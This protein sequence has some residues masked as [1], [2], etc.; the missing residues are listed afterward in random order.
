MFALVDLHVVRECTRTRCDSVF[1]CSIFVLLVRSKLITGV[2]CALKFSGKSRNVCQHF[3]KILL[4]LFFLFSYLKTVTK[5]K[6]YKCFS[7]IPISEAKVR[8]SMDVSCSGFKWLDY[9]TGF[10]EMGLKKRNLCFTKSQKIR[11]LKCRLF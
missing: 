6:E 3:R 8:C 10:G 1:K 11:F 4:A 9:G 5:C 7:N 2:P